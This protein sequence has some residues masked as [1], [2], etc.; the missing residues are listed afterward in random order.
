MKVTHNLVFVSDGSETS[1]RKFDRAFHSLNLLEQ[2]EDI[3]L[4]NRISIMYNKFSSKHGQQINNSNINMIG[5][6][7]RI[8]QAT[9][10]Q[11]ISKIHE[12]QIFDKLF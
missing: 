4:C 1:N 9:T 6:V 8:E 11:L 5:G 10:A 7:P 2:Q 12:M 3:A